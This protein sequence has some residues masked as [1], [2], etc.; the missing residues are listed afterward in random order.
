MLPLVGQDEQAARGLLGRFQ[1][2]P[3]EVEKRVEML[4]GGERS[5][6]RLLTLLVGDA[7][8]LLLDEPTNH[9]DMGS[10]EALADALEDYTGTI[11]LVTHDRHLID[12]VATRVLEIHDGGLLNHLSAAGTG[13]RATSAW[14]SRRRRKTRGRGASAPAERRRPAPPSRAARRA[15]RRHAAGA[16]VCAAPRRRSSGRRSGSARSTRSSPSPDLRR[17]G[18]AQ[19]PARRARR[20]RGPAEARVRGLG[21]ARRRRGLSAPLRAVAPRPRRSVRRQAWQRLAAELGISVLPPAR[22]DP[23]SRSIDPPPPPTRLVAWPAVPPAYD[24]GA[25]E[26]SRTWRAVRG[27]PK[28]DS[29]HRRFYLVLLCLLAAALLLPAAAQALTFDQAID[30]LVAQGYP[31]QVERQLNS[32]GT[33]ALGMRMGGTSADNAAAQYIADEMKRLGMANVRL[34]KVAVDKWEW[35][36]ASVTVNGRELT[37]T[38]FGG[39]PPTPFG[40]ATG[41]LVYAGL[42]SAADFEALGDVTGKIVIVDFASDY[43][44]INLPGL[45]AKVRGAKAVIMTYNPLFP[46]YYGIA[47]TLSAPTTA[48]TTPMPAPWCTCARTTATGSRAWSR[49]APPP[50]PSSTT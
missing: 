11:L 28:G 47:P 42:G 13:R 45:E 17:P 8:F 27:D 12:R 1:F 44:W 35:R 30:Q 29:M 23:R 4:S 7:N 39:V 15:P 21:E 38:S 14:A 37:A 3:D 16:P 26:A 5:R 50:P 40:G 25:V 18:R 33:S 34:E 46:Y 49:P 19:P 10:V 9:L 22:P 32:Y 24:G 41:E 31:Q 48:P 43:C 6:L 36:G 2:G 20:R